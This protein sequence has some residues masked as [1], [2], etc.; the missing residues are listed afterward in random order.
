M[1][2]Q[3]TNT[4]QAGASSAL[5]MAQVST[6]HRLELFCIMNTTTESA[7]CAV[8][9]TPGC[10]DGRGKDFHKGTRFG[11]LKCEYTGTPP[12]AEAQWAEDPDAACLWCAGTGHPYGDES[13]GMCECPKPEGAK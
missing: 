3:Q 8:C 10:A 1:K 12:F 2:H 6:V 9:G 4:A 7:V 11:S 5:F 13:F